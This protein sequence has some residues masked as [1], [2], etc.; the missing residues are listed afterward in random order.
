MFMLS[1]LPVNM[2]NMSLNV[3]P[4]IW[5]VNA[6]GTRIK[7]RRFVE[8]HDGLRRLRRRV[9]VRRCDVTLQIVAT[10]KTFVALFAGDA[11]NSIRVTV[12]RSHFV[13]TKITLFA[14][15]LLNWIFPFLLFGFAIGHFIFVVLV[16]DVT[17]E[18]VARSKRFVA[19]V[20]L[21][22]V[23][24]DGVAFDDGAAVR[25]EAAQVAGKLLGRDSSFVLLFRCSRNGDST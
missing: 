22:V 23:S 25:A 9:R 11:V 17:N 8:S 3:I 15:E 19:V 5:R 14:T 4:A 18:I 12:N 24:S 16:V 6:I 21:E 13:G 20:T 7:F 1:F 10:Q 2:L